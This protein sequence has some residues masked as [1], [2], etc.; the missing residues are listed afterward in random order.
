MSLIPA[1]LSGHAPLDP[2][3]PP[4]KDNSCWP[5]VAH[6]AVAHVK[7][8]ASLANSMSACPGTSSVSALPVQ[9]LILSV[10]L[11]SN[12]PFSDS[13]FHS[14]N[15]LDFLL[16][17][18]RPIIMLK[19]CFCSS[20]RGGAIFTLMN[21]L[22]SCWYGYVFIVTAVSFT[23]SWFYPVEHPAENL[24]TSLVSPVKYIYVYSEPN[25]QVNQTFNMHHVSCERLYGSLNLKNRLGGF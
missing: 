15:L 24:A 10:C 20:G 25:V 16:Y 22:M 19:R 9:L 4:P 17:R 14:F 3:T 18:N 21:M 1:P 2:L 8:G 6:M 13:H 7:G 23:S 12:R 11:P 5:L